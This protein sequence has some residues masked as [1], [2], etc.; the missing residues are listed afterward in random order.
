MSYYTYN[1]PCS[2]CERVVPHTINEDFEYAET[3]CPHCKAESFVVF[4]EAEQEI[5]QDLF[6]ENIFEAERGI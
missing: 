6:A 4:G 5:L 2:E 3:T 1:L